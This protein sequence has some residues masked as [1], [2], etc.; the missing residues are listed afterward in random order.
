MMVVVKRQ[1]TIECAYTKCN[2]ITV[3]C[4][5][6]DWQCEKLQYSTNRYQYRDSQHKR[7]QSFAQ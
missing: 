6:L 2:S 1:E 7:S 3:S 4:G 5:L